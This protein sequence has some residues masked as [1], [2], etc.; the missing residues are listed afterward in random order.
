MID[1]VMRILVMF[2]LPVKKKRER[3]QYAKFRK[4][5]L[6]DGYSMMQ[7]SIYSRITR[8][9]DDMNKH[10]HRLEKHL[11]PKGSVRVM[12]VTEKQYNGMLILVGEKT[13]N[14]NYLIPSDL[15]DT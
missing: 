1:R 2:D 9:H 15:M 10:V 14:E 12:V 13:A 11:P 3:K 6:T 8:N 4:F 5:L 7:F